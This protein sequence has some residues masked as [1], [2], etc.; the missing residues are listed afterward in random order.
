MSRLKS[1]FVGRLRVELPDEAERLAEALESTEPSVS[2]RVNPV[3]EGGRCFDGENDKVAW[4]GDGRYL[5]CRPDFTLDPAMH[6]GRYYVQDAS[7][8]IRWHKLKRPAL[9]RRLCRAGR[10]D[11]CGMRGAPGR[12]IGGG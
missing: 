3:K 6:Q 5:D 4:C 9:S 11:H 8:M 12:R 7:S 10:K 2:V 1:E